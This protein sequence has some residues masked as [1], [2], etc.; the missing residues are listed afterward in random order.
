MLTLKH[1]TLIIIFIIISAGAAL[2]QTVDS[3]KGTSDT[4][5]SDR[6]SWVEKSENHLHEMNIIGGYSFTSTKG[7]WGKIPQATLSLYAIRYNHKLFTYNTKH[8]VEYVTEANISANYT[9]SNADGYQAESY[10]GFGFTPLGFQLNLNRYNTI[11][12]FFKSSAG[13]MVFKKRFPNQQGTQFNFTLELG[14]GI[15]IMLLRNL[16]FTVG[17]K[18][19]H[20]SNGQFGQ[21]NPGVDS[22]IFYSGLTFF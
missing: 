18:Y 21:I 16:S 11:Q 14:G 4:R 12:P 1:F 8:I 6:F 13:F 17:Y 22:N 3:T 7:F 2:S 5:F 19:H 15:E 20:L 9:L 10:S